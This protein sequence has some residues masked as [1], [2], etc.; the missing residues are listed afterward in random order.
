MPSKP[1][2]SSLPQS[3][4]VKKRRILESLSIPAEEYH[5]LSPKDSIDE[6]IRDLIDEINSLE[7]FVTTSSCGGRVSVFLEGKRAT[8]RGRSSQ[9]DEDGKVEGDGVEHSSGA[10]AK[11]TTAGVGGKGGGGRWLFVSHNKASWEEEMDL[12]GLLG[13]KRREPQPP[14]DIG[15][16]VVHFKFEPMASYSRCIRLDPDANAL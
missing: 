2:P 8:E 10:K 11:D 16:R 15:A 12:A 14:R 3:F 5:D 1:D 6:S 13:M 7:G 9:Q 4:L